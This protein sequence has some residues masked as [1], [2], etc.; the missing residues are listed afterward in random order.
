M[1]VLDDGSQGSLDC[2]R[3]MAEVAVRFPGPFPV[4][5][6]CSRELARESFARALLAHFQTRIVN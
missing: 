6:I 3:R 1:I 5:G 4:A 2:S